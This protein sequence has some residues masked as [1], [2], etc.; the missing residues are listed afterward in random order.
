MTRGRELQLM[1]SG[2]LQ[3]LVKLDEM[4]EQLKPD[5][6]VE[7]SVSVVSDKE[8]TI[9]VSGSAHKLEGL[10]IELIKRRPEL[11]QVLADAAYHYGQNIQDK[12]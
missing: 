1:I 9:V 8:N 3:E 11:R 4:N 5:D 10:F 6:K 7:H 2:R 12:L